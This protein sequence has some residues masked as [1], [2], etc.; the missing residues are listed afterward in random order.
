MN[1]SANA[2]SQDLLALRAAAEAWGG[3]LIIEQRAELELKVRSMRGERY[4]R[5]N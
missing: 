3:S 5:L 2:N 4:P 1:E